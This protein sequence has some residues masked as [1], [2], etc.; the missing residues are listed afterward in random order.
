MPVLMGAAACRCR[1]LQRFP[2]VPR[3]S[4]KQEEASAAAAANLG[5]FATSASAGLPYPLGCLI[6]K[7]P[8]PG[9]AH[10]LLPRPG[11][12]GFLHLAR[13]AAALPT[14]AAGAAPARPSLCPAGAAGGD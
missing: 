11:L 13:S 1:P 2:E 6:R 12:S 8:Q 14:A 5:G 10:R 3:L 7:Q 9:A 4:A